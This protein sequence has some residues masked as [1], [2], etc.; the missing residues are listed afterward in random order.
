MGS[1]GGGGGVERRSETGVVAVEG[2][3]PASKRVAVVPTRR[4][5]GG[6][7]G[8]CFRVFYRGGSVRATRRRR[9]AVCA[10]LTPSVL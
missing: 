10:G 1:E 5:V 3:V 2:Y 9:P 4:V 7:F 8:L 6:G